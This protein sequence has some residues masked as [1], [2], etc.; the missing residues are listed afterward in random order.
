MAIIGTPIVASTQSVISART[1]APT[2]SSSMTYAVGDLITNKGELYRCKTEIPVA[3]PWNDTHWARI[4]LADVLKDSR[5][6]TYIFSQSP[7]SDVWTIHHNL[8][9]YP[10]VTVVDNA[11]NIVIGNV[12][13]EDR[14][15]VVITFVAA[16]S[17]KA[18]LN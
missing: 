3:E 6:D 16:F 13:Y 8:D 7:A 11:G 17:G 10:S 4:T 9:K 5:T 14:N 15:T 1:I 18:Y 2:Y 12:S